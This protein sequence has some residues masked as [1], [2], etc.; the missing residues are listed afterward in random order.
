MHNLR[1][2]APW[3]PPAPPDSHSGDGASCLSG[4]LLGLGDASIYPEWT[5]AKPSHILLFVLPSFPL[6][7]PF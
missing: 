4:P 1:S 2:P 3:S 7:F 5:L 6:C